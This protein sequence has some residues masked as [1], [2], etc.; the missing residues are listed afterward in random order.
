MKI[1]LKKPRTVL[2][3]LRLYRVYREAFPPMERKPFGKIR[4]MYREGRADVWCLM[5]E[6]RF[7]GLATT[8]NGGDLILLDYFAIT[9]G[10]RGQGFGTQAMKLLLETYDD[11][12]FFLEIESTREQAQNLRERLRRK[13]FYE[14]CGM[15]PM[16]T[17]A[18]VFGIRMELLG[19]RC[20][21]DIDG[22][23]AFYRDHY[24]AWA[25]EHIREV[26]T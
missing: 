3:W 15:L 16:D 11:K 26:T 12:G 2:D 6:G 25:A 17:E 23:R 7:R 5:V 10:C 9:K 8:V 20:H 4:K 22:Y 24:S 1:S 13:A 18:D 14:N 19:V 21:L